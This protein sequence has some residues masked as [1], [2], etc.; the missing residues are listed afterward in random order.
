MGVV[1]RQSIQNTISTYLGFGLGAINTL[2]LYTRILPVS[3]YGLLSIQ[4]SVATLLLPLFLF[5]LPNTII[6]FYHKNASTE[7]SARLNAFSLYFPLL[8]IFLAFV[9]VLSFRSGIFPFLL[10]KYAYVAPYSWHILGISIGMTYFEIGYAQARMVLK[11]AFGNI[12]KEIFHRFCIALGL[13]GL[14]FDWLTLEQFFVFLVGIHFLRAIVMYVY[15]WR[16]CDIS[17]SFRRPEKLKSYLN[18]SLFMFLGGTAAVVIL[19]IDKLMIYT[20]VN[21]DQVAFYTVAVFMATIVGV[22][23]RSMYQIT[24]PITARLLHDNDFKGLQSLYKQSSLNLAM[25][26]GGVLLLLAV[27]LETI[28]KFIPQAYGGTTVLVLLI[29][30]SKF[31]DALLGNNNAIL[32]NS[33]YYKS[34]LRFGLFLAFM[35]VVLNYL[36]IPKFGIMGAAIASFLAITFYDTAKVIYVN[37]KYNMHPFSKGTAY[38]LIIITVS[39]TLAQWIPNL[40]NRYMSIGVNTLFTAIVY[41]GLLYFSNISATFNGLVNRGKKRLF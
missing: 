32:F 10:Q 6:K 40:E 36:F 28:Y 29:G 14:Y 9:F 33:P 16:N 18:Y 30:S 23:A 1:V 25:A 19:E 4:L 41:V 22:P 31:C 20:F 7:E 37:V 5:G 15:L 3:S 35:T 21:I 2:V 17:F 34:I 26:A 27:N 24:A 8:F 13:I 11:T 38:L 39:F 12:L